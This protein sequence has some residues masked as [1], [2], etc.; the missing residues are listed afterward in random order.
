LRQGECANLLPKK[1]WE[2]GGSRTT[3][4]YLTLLA[5]LCF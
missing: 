5:Y 1:S 2:Q 3:A 4:S